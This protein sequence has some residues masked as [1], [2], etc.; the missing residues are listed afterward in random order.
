RDP[1]DF[2]EQRRAAASNRGNELG[3]R[4]ERFDKGVRIDAETLGQACAPLPADVG[5]RFSQGFAV[6]A[7]LCLGRAGEMHEWYGG[8]RHKFEDTRVRERL[9]I[10]IRV[11]VTARILSV[12][13][14][15]ARA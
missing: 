3:L 10:D 2:F 6:L 8:K 4:E 7:P 13:L 11:V 15:P 9:K 12:P 14:R 5:D 1:F